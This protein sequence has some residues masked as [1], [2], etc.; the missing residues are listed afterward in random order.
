[1]V[2]NRYDVVTI[3]LDGTISRVITEEYVLRELA[4]ERLEKYYELDKLLQE[5]YQKYYEKAVTEQFKLLIGLKVSEIKRVFET[6]PLAKN[7]DKAI[8]LLNDHGFEVLILTDNI[9]VFCEGIRD[10]IGVRRYI[11]SRTIVK[12]DVIVGLGELN[13]R[14]D[15]GL[16]KYLEKNNID[17]A[18]V[19]H[20][21]DWK[22]DVPVFNLVGLGIAYRP[23]DNKIIEEAHLTINIEDFEKVAKL[24]IALDKC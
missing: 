6:I 15:Q 20:V 14:K 1:M 16:K 23:K 12:N 22:N 24:I 13:L 11:S 7:V 2:G 17:P 3:D 8:R 10:R 21:G 4:P 19:I 9:D 5:D 18:R